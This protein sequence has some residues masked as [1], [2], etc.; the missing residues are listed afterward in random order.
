MTTDVRQ[1]GD[2]FCGNSM[3]VSLVSWMVAFMDSGSWAALFLVC[4]AA[5]AF[6]FVRLGGGPGE[7]VGPDL[8]ADG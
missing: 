1:R 7:V 2:A 6:R 5:S 3:F 8:R 4:A